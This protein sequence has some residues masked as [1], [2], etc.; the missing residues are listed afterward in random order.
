MMV[1]LLRGIDRD[2]ATPTLVLGRASG[3]FLNEIPSDVDVREFGKDRAVSS[4]LDIAREFRRGKY[5][6]CFSMVSMNMAAVLGRVASREAVR[7]VLG[8]RSNYTQSIG[9]EA[10]FARLKLAGVRVL[11]PLADMVVAVSDGVRDDLVDN[12]KVP[13]RKVITIHN[14][15]DL[16]AVRAAAAKQPAHPWLQGDRR[17]SLLVAVGA[18]RPAKGYPDLLDAFRRVRAGREVRL[19]ILGEGPLRPWIED[20]IAKHALERDVN[21]LGF[22]ANP[23]M[24]V[25]RA[26]LFVH[27]AW[28]EGFP[29]VIAEAMACGV[30]V[31]ATDCPSGPAEIIRSGE[32]GVLVPVHAPA[33]LAS[34]IASLLDDEARRDAY[35]KRAASNIERLAV[36]SVVRRYEDVFMSVASEL[37]RESAIS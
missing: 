6:V 33:K 7:L 18:L 12:L 22:Q 13:S 11:Y 21:L 30:P 20:Y 16:V 27:A 29:N 17:P 19:L 9:A 2:R 14:P 35:A 5:D 24:Y 8:A 34:A 32:D 10:S 37:R 36:D 4:I 28:W 31:V 26:T 1:H 25:S 3:P 15:V 23:H